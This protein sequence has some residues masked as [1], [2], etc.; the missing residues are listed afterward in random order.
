MDEL[1]KR[2]HEE[3][4]NQDALIK[5]QQQQAAAPTDNDE[6]YV[7]EYYDNWKQQ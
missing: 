2:Y 5:A 6:K 1:L 7:Q 3:Q 4:A